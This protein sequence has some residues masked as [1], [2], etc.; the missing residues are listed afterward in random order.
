MT[1]WKM[2]NY[3][4]GKKLSGYRA[5]RRGNG[6]NKQSTEDLGGSEITLYD[7]LNGE[8]MSFYICLNPQNA[9]YQES[10]L[11]QTMDLQ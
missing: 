4:E 1:F 5:Y 9:Q 7:T 6:L 2:Q 8:Y 10:T 3:E 11:M